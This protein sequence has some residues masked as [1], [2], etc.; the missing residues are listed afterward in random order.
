MG[1][2]WNSP[3][4]QIIAVGVICFCCPGMFNALNSLGGGG[5]V[6]SKIGQNAN[7]AIYTCF[8]LFGLLAG[9]VHNKL[10]P[11]WTAFTGCIF[12]CIYVGSYV[13]YNHHKTSGFSVAAGA[14]LGF[15]AALLW[16]AQ[17]AMMMAYPA[18]QDKAKYIAYFWT[19]FNSGSVVGSFI[20]LGL[21]Y[22]ASVGN[23][24]DPIYIAFMVL[25]AFGTLVAL[26]LATPAS[27]VRDNGDKIK[28][29]AFPTWT[30]EVV[31]TLKLFLDWRM[32]VLIPM[33][34]SSNWFYSYQFSTVNGPY[35]TPR[36]NSFNN[37][38]YWGS[39]IF[40]SWTFARFLD[41]QGL[42]R[43]TRG[44]WGLAII[45]IMFII[46]WTGGIFFQKTYT[47]N[48]KPFAIDFKSDS[49]AAIE[50]HDS[51]E[52]HEVEA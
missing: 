1:I 28:I 10:G 6:D 48:D 20:G 40:G 5:Q 26:S 14:G 41:Y 39:Q 21:N 45:S 15:G 17:G 37:I 34:L 19:I 16:T 52:K 43:R 7:V 47:E 8:A 18:E 12:Y 13:S 44:V 9:A 46:T 33:F 36:T 29:Q 2:R 11:K 49:A 51:K 31:A 30:G 42:N 24:G 22:N 32:V 4:M 38:F 25:M 27:I 3:L 35:F 50:Q 23:L